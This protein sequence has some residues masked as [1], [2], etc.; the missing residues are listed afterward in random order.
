MAKIIGWRPFPLGNTGSATEF[1]S[2]FVYRDNLGYVNVDELKFV[3]R[4]LE[5]KMT[6]EEIEEMIREADHDNDGQIS[7][8]GDNH[9]SYFF[10]K[11]IYVTRMHCCRISLNMFGGGRVGAWGH[12]FLYL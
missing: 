12:G 5:D 8:D 10:N 9:F 2:V 1:L 4:H 3:M 7:Y 11:L 6:E